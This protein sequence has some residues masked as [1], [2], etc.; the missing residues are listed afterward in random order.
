MIA[1]AKWPFASRGDDSGTHKAEIRLWAD[2]RGRCAGGLRSLVPGNGLG[3]GDD[4]QYL[5]GDG[6]LCVDGSRHLD[7]LRNKG[8]HR[9]LVQGDPR[10][11]NQ[12][13][14]ILVIP[15]GIP[16]SGRSRA[17]D[18]WIGSFRA[19]GRRRSASYSIDGQSLFFRMR[20][21][22]EDSALSIGD[23][24]GR[25]RWRGIRRGLMRRSRKRHRR[26][27]NNAIT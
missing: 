6:C 14:I 20:S 16:G 23:I 12:Y 11:F 9:V 26:G 4:A 1:A 5:G 2:G 25:H 15:I 3:N 10:L 18:S 21:G 8:D 27:K 22:E 17:G 24:D 7:R 13:G 19:P